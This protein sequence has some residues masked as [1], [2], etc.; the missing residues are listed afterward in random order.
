[1]MVGEGNG[2]ENGL[3]PPKIMNGVVLYTLLPPRDMAV[4]DLRR[5]DTSNVYKCHRY[6][7]V[8]VDNLDG[9]SEYDVTGVMG[10][11]RAPKSR[12]GFPTAL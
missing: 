5:Y 6:P 3:A 8:A 12:K 1:M 10:L 2:M 7:R 4:V 11:P 9:E